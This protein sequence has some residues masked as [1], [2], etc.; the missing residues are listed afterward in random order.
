MNAHNRC[1]NTPSANA[2]PVIT[3]Y[4]SKDRWDTPGEVNSP[5]TCITGL[6][7]EG[8]RFI[9]ADVLTVAEDTPAQSSTYRVTCTPPSS[10]RYLWVRRLQRLA[11]GLCC[12][13]MEVDEENKGAG[14]LGDMLAIA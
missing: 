2:H 11:G 10:R 8:F 4:I 3:V 6:V 7:A 9:A 5:L 14:Q 13:S 1:N 12:G